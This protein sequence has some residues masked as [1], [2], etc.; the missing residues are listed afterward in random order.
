MSMVLT[1]RTI[2]KTLLSKN[3]FAIKHIWF[4]ESA[5]ADSITSKVSYLQKKKKN[6]VTKRFKP[7]GPRSPND[8][9]QTKDYVYKE[10]KLEIETQLDKELNNHYLVYGATF[11]TSD[12][13][14]TPIKNTTQIRLHQIRF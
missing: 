4:T 11:T 14:K 1:I 13:K 8:N 9:L 12:I 3:R 2:L 7:A 6:G 10:D 5:I